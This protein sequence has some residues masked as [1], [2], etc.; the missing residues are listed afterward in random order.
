MNKLGEALKRREQTAAGLMRPMDLE[1]SV[2]SPS[3]KSPSL[4]IKTELVEALSYYKKTKANIG[5][6]VEK[7]TTLLKVLHV[8]A[9]NGGI[10]REDLLKLLSD[11]ET[12]LFSDLNGLSS[13]FQAKVYEKFIGKGYL[14]VAG[15]SAARVP[16]FYLHQIGLDLIEELNLCNEN[17]NRE[18]ESKASSKGYTV[19]SEELKRMH[20]LID[21]YKA[22]AGDF[23]SRVFMHES[24]ATEKKRQVTLK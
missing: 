23:E 13:A 15:D 12:L 18:S 7:L 22:T 20:G 16:Y 24:K 1:L 5:P 9:E 21:R 14:D 8:V 19:T 10:L 2:Q 17:L 3:F 4:K 6:S 11:L